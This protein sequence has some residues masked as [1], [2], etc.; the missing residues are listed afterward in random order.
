[1][2]LLTY[3]TT[4]DIILTNNVSHDTSLPYNLAF[5]GLAD[6]VT[7]QLNGIANVSASPFRFLEFSIHIPNDI[8]LNTSQQYR[9]EVI[10]GDGKVVVDEIAM[11][12]TNRVDT[13][14]NDSN[15][16]TR[17]FYE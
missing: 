2:L 12:S 9:I 7:Y 15:N 4:N 10:S 5:I 14:Y 1:M 8:S 3:N 11:F 13:I 16:T 6:N 17:K